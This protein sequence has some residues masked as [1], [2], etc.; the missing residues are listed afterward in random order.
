[1]A[2]LLDE[3]HKDAYTPAVSAENTAARDSIDRLSGAAFDR[4]IR[5]FVIA[6]HSRGIAMMDDYIPKAKDSRVKALAERMR[7]AQHAEITSF[8]S[9]V[10]ATK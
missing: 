6:H 10:S 1:M 3:K 4:A 9:R 5:Q 2:T 8:R 7:A